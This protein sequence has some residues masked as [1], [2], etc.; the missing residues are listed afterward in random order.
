MIDA[1]RRRK[2]RD[3]RE[4]VFFTDNAADF[5]A[6]SPADNISLIINAKVA[7]ALRKISHCPTDLVARFGGEEFAIILGGTDAEGL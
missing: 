2:D 4:R 5:P 6:G 7:E 3:D 1:H